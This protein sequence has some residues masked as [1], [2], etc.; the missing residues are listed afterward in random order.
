MEGDLLRP[1]GWISELPYVGPAL[2]LSFQAA[3]FLYTWPLSIGVADPGATFFGSLYLVFAA[4]F[5]WRRRY[6]AAAFLMIVPLAASW[7]LFDLIGT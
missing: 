4:L 1:V 5:V 6:V 3:L 7:W 2:A